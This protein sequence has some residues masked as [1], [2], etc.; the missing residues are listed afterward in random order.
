MSKGKDLAQALKLECSQ[1]FY[2]AWGNF[3]APITSYP[4]VLFDE[5]GFIIIN[6][7]AELG[8]LGIKIGKRT[9][10]PN[11][12]SSLP[13]YTYITAYRAQSADEICDDY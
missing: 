4:C 2:S 13:S 10:V 1:A 3:Y 5:C 6:S 11:K 9:N 12:I 8:A 7:P